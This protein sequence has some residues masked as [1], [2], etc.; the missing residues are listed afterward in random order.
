[1]VRLPRLLGR[2]RA[3]EI[4][5]GADDFDGESAE[6]DGYVNR[7]PP[8]ADLDGFVVALASRINPQ[9]HGVT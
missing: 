1:M 5:L 7:A 4:L 2:G 6:R 9:N 3:L 8:D